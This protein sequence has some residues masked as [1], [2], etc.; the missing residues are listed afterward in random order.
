V[1]GGNDGGNGAT[2]GSAGCS[3]AAVRGSGAPVS[4]LLAGGAMAVMALAGRRRRR[5]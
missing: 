5:R 3:S 4:G 2:G 1:A